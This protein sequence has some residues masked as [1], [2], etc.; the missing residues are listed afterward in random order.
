MIW[1]VAL[2]MVVQA[3]I[4]WWLIRRARAARNDNRTL[5][6]SLDTA[7]RI[8]AQAVTPEELQTKL[9][10]IGAA[11]QDWIDACM[12][13]LEATESADAGLAAA[14]EALKHKAAVPPAK[15]EPTPRRAATGAQAMRM[16]ETAVASA[17][18]DR[19]DVQDVGREG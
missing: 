19:A 1:F 7:Q 5:V 11:W 13:R 15:K 17:D 4:N 12:R 3:G 16:I 8:A 14:V 9:T 2:G 10:G 18:A 6:R